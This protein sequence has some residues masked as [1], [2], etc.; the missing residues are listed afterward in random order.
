M[1][2]FYSF[3]S[4]F[5]D[6]EETFIVFLKYVQ[7]FC[8]ILRAIHS[9][10]EDS[11]VIAPYV[12]AKKAKRIE[13]DR[14]VEVLKKVNP[15]FKS[16]LPECLLIPGGEEQQTALLQLWSLVFDE[17]ATTIY[18]SHL[19]FR[20]M[21]LEVYFTLLQTASELNGSLH[22][23]NHTL[24]LMQN[25]LSETLVTGEEARFG[26]DELYMFLKSWLEVFNTHITKFLLV[27]FDQLSKNSDHENSD[28]PKW[29]SLGLL[30]RQS[31]LIY[32]ECLNGQYHDL[33]SILALSLLRQL[34]LSLNRMLTTYFWSILIDCFQIGHQVTLAPL[35]QLL[36]AF[37]GLSVNS[38]LS[39]IKVMTT[40]TDRSSEHTR[41][42]ARQIF[43]VEQATVDKSPFNGPTFKAQLVDGMDN[44]D[45]NIIIETASGVNQRYA[46]FHI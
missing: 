46:C 36:A 13:V 35:I 33:I 22:I 29:D 30:F 41:K 16:H 43:F 38:D 15:S 10:P 21:L 39:R 4:C 24:P 25:I 17:Y 20:P 45:F 37:T 19:Q 34:L 11:F 3:V 9:V 31:I 6:I 23:L 14:L 2:Y 42:R 26:I 40:R 1:F 27:H 18:V 32:I 28:G 7:K 5:L 8:K 12:R 44:R